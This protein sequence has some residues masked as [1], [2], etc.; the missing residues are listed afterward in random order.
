[1]HQKHWKFVQETPSSTWLITNVPS[2]AEGSV[3][4]HIETDDG[5]ILQPEQQRRVD[6]YIELLFGVQE[7][8][9]TAYGQYYLEEDTT[10]VSGPGGVVNVTI[11]QHTQPQQ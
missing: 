9:G 8:T 11:N 1:M 10:V 2:G 3:V 5:V 6:G 7:I 4:T